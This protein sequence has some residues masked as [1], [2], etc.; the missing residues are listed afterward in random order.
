MLLYRYAAD[1]GCIRA[2]R[3]LGHIYG[4]GG[5]DDHE[6]DVDLGRSA[7][8][9]LKGARSGDAACQFEYG[10]C[11]YLGYGA[12]ECFADAYDWFSLSAEQGNIDAMFYLG[13]MYRNGYGIQRDRRKASKWYRR[14]AKQHH[15]YARM[16]L[17]RMYRVGE[18]SCRKRRISEHW[19]RPLDLYAD[20][21]VV[22]G[23]KY[24]EGYE[25]VESIEDAVWWYRLSAENGYPNGQ[26]YLGNLYC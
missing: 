13:E 19:M 24:E 20:E 23:L 16:N 5:D 17:A 9:Y 6:I 14:A 1:R 12:A 8:W 25:V 2:I 15:L 7:E 4:Y 11:C 10:L 22:M 18:I 3:R 21:T 26:L